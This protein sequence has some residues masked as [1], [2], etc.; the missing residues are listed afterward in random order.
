[1]M[2]MRQI[3]IKTLTG[4]RLVMALCIDQLAVNPSEDNTTAV[5]HIATGFAIVKFSAWHI[6]Y[7]FARSIQWIDFD[8]LV[9]ML[10]GEIPMSQEGRDIAQYLTRRN[11]HE[12]YVAIPA[13]LKT[14]KDYRQRAK[15]AGL[16]VQS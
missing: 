5:T 16:E 9:K 7:N 1:M 2:Q 15:R 14:N 6:A 8:M 4:D 12:T 11:K 13:I 10:D 3:T